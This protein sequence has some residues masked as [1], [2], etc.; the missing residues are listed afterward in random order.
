MPGKS[1]DAAAPRLGLIVNPIAG[2]GGRV[3]LKGTDG[4]GVAARALELGAEP[5]ATSRASAALSRL[6]VSLPPGY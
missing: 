3:G 4:A 1:P 6:L 5:M 2:L